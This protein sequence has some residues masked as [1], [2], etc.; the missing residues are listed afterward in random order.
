MAFCRPLG[1]RRELLVCTVNAAADHARAV[2]INIG[3]SAIQ[4]IPLA[5]HALATLPTQSYPL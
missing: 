1:I 2:E 3:T 4:L 5:T